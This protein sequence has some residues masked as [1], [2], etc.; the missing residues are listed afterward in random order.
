MQD[1]TLEVESD[2]VASQKVKG[3]KDRK[4][5]PTDPLGASSSENK[6]EK[7]AKLLDNLTAEICKLKDRGKIPVRGKGPSDFVPR[8]PN[9]V[10]YRRGNPLVQILRRESNQGEDQK[11]RAPFHND[12]LEEELE[13]IEEEVEAKDNI[14]C[15][16]DEVDYSFLTQAEYEEALMDEKVSEEAVYQAYDQEG[17]NLWSK[18]ISPPKK[19][20]VPTKK[21]ATLAKRIVVPPKKMAA[22]PKQLQ[23]PLQSLS[24]DPIQ[25][26]APS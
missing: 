23:R 5:Q 21:H 9:F 8:N 22:T 14:H 7:M 1:A 17:Y 11:I 4:K 25:L 16:E 2:I 18:L 3:K 24:P 19:N 20:V 26:K 12:G 6:I 13:F 15:M 10:P